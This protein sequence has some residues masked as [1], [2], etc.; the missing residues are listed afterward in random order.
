MTSSGLLPIEDLIGQ[1]AGYTTGG[2]PLFLGLLTIGFFAGF[3]MLQGTRL[4]AKIVVLVPA[5]FLTL[6]FI[7]GLAVLIALGLATI[8]YLAFTKFLYIRG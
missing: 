7:P 5:L 6:Y 3:T 1:G 4:E 8:L 2:D